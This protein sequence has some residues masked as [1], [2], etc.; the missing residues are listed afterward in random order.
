MRKVY[1][2]SSKGLPKQTIAFIKALD[3]R[4]SLFRLATDALI[5]GANLQDVEALS[6]ACEERADWGYYEPF[7]SM[8]WAA[9]FCGKDK[10]FEN[11]EE[12]LEA[13]E[14]CKRS[15][16]PYSLARELYKINDR[17]KLGERIVPDKQQE[18]KTGPTSFADTV[19][20]ASRVRDQQPRHPLA[21][22]KTI[23][24]R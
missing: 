7:Y 15:S 4:T 16:S 5:A 24:V 10:P 11:T 8:S 20:L 21:K 9:G 19:Q 12:I 17:V 2:A 6:K 18:Q 13:I 22:G 23:A 3:E 14:G 1:E